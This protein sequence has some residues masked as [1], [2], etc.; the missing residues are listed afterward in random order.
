M[1]HYPKKV[2]SLCHVIFF[3]EKKECRFSFSFFSLSP[4]PLP[5]PFWR[6][7]D[8]FG[9][10]QIPHGIN[11]TTLDAH[12]HEIESSL[13]IPR[14]GIKGQ[15]YN[16][17]CAICQSVRRRKDPTFSWYSFFCDVY[18][19]QFERFIRAW[20]IDMPGSRTR[21]ENPNGSFFRECVWY[22]HQLDQPEEWLL[23]A[24]RLSTCGPR[25]SAK[26]RVKQERLGTSGGEKSSSDE[27]GQAL[28]NALLPR[29]ENG[30]ANSEGKSRSSENGG[31]NQAVDSGTGSTTAQRIP[32]IGQADVEGGVCG[33]VHD[34]SDSRVAIIP[35][36]IQQTGNI[37]GNGSIAPTQQA[38]SL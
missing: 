17:I 25:K 19:R 16:Y 12:G 2:P 18:E 4:P 6:F 33:T 10:P 26:I 7:M 22:I 29:G 36:N 32:P 27:A 1:T 5:S 14:T 38:K 9:Q 20:D 28:P 8:S 13:Q 15:V 35:E 37:G 11:Y 3:S 23:F 30:T 24:A 34:Q 21:K 31:C